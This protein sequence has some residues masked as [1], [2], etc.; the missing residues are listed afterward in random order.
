ME[1]P[2]LDLTLLFIRKSLVSQKKFKQLLPNISLVV[3]VL[4]K[5]TNSP[6]PEFCKTS[7]EALFFLALR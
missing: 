6:M 4:L 2:Q 1:G 7:E 3:Y 5:R